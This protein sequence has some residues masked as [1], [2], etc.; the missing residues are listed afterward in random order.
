MSARRGALA[1]AAAASAAVA[2]AL[3][4]MSAPTVAAVAS[5]DE[6]H[7]TLQ[8]VGTMHTSWTYHPQT[9]ED[10][11]GCYDTTTFG[12]GHQQVN[13]NTFRQHVNVTIV[14]SG[15]SI[16]FQL[17][18]KERAG[19]RHRGVGF[20]LADVGRAGLIET[21]FAFA[22]NHSLTCGP[23]PGPQK[24]GEAMPPDP[25]VTDDSGCGGAQFPW[26][27]SPIDVAGK[28]EIGLAGFLPSDM[29]KC[30]IFAHPGGDENGTIPAQATAHIPL[31][32]LRDALTPRHGKL[33]IHFSHHYRFSGPMSS[34]KDVTTTTDVTWKI[35]LIR[36]HPTPVP[37][38][39]LPQ[40]PTHP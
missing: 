26:D 40:P 3:A 10:P 13:Y 30:P 28:F 24:I 1:L 19:P 17:D 16:A 4:T 36:A 6:Q 35:T 38:S 8:F 9:L 32:E 5:L 37:P 2:A 21:D 23:P 11:G 12:S 25:D 31:N 14:D 33:T 29:V 7:A 27:V 18:P 22:Q 15:G 34:A 39:T 20:P